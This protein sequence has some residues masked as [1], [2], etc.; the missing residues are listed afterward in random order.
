[1]G[2][3]QKMK[4]FTLYREGNCY[5]GNLHIHTTLSDGEKTPEEIKDVYKNN[6]YS[7]VAIT[8][9]NT[10]PKPYS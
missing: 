5:K 3:S 9:H 6:G 1:M 7:F 8:D 10:L 4:K 2:G